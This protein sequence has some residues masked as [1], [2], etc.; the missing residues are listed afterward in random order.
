M[1][2][3]RVFI[4]YSHDSAQ[5]KINVL[6]LANRLRH[7]GIDAWIDRYVEFPEEGWPQWMTNQISLADSILIVCSETYRHRFEGSA[8]PPGGMGA[9]RE[10]LIINQ[11]L[12]EEMGKNKKKFIPVFFEG[13]SKDSIPLE[14]RPYNYF[15][16]PD[17]YEK[18]YRLL[19]D[20]PE[21]IKP[22]IGKIR[23]LP[24][25][26]SSGIVSHQPPLDS[27][28][29]V[30][31][32][33]DRDLQIDAVTPETAQTEQESSA[34]K[35]NEDTISILKSR[36]KNKQLSLI[37]G[38]GISIEAGLPTWELLLDSL[39]VKYVSSNYGTSSDASV[40]EAL[41]K[42]FQHFSPIILA[43]F[44]RSRLPYDN[45]VDLVRDSLYENYSNQVQPT[46]LCEEIT[47]LAKNLKC[48]VNFNFDDLLEDALN[49]ADIEATAIWNAQGLATVQGLPVYHPHGF[50]PRSG[51]G[52]K[53]IV[54]AESDYHSQY[55][56]SSNWS[57][58]IVSRVLME[59]S[60]LFVGTSLTDPN[61]RRLVD[62]AYR[63]MQTPQHFLFAR[64]PEVDSDQG[65]STALDAL[66]EILTASYQQTGITPIWFSDFDEILEILAKVRS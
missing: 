45:F 63:E 65:G 4:S 59:S 18:L 22:S 11:A 47:L 58:I 15:K 29:V 1:S 2:P 62:S 56:S 12:Y 7:E 66:V 9:R 10:G 34:F 6:E 19:T 3:I 17:D 53:S 46:R 61:L 21:L 30:S 50:I 55:F 27:I 24:P 51:Q 26:G 16:L 20:Q 57:N 23:H 8:T 43:Q 5:H 32:G 33:A 49:S 36:W 52:S 28:S 37:T 13:T 48:I 38:A 64:L 31:A 40:S 25:L 41:K 44:L 54:L 35:A 60:C 39:I 42:E 14:L